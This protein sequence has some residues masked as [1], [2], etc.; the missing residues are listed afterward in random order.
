MT[1]HVHACLVSVRNVSKRWLAKQCGHGNHKIYWSEAKARYHKIVD[2]MWTFLF[3]SF[4]LAHFFT[5]TWNCGCDALVAVRWGMCRKCSRILRHM[6]LFRVV[7]QCE[8]CG[9]CF[10]FELLGM[11]VVKRETK[12]TTGIC[13]QNYG[14]WPVWQVAPVAFLWQMSPVDFSRPLCLVHHASSVKCGTVHRIFK[15]I[16]AIAYNCALI[17]TLHT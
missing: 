8:H 6:L 17:H 13:S 3:T 14:Q 10:V 15:W 5:V 12:F 9:V 1:L 16:F 4:S 11:F 7:V 2:R